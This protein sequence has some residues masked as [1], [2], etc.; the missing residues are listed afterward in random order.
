[1][2][3]QRIVFHVPFKLGYALSGGGIRPGKLIRAF[4]D[5]G[6]AVDVVS[7]FKAQR[8]EAMAAIEDRLAQG[9]PYAFCYAESSVLP[10]MLTEKNQKAFYPFVDFDFFAKLK[11]AG[12]PIGLFYR[13][14]YWKYPYFRERFSWPDRMRRIFFYRLDW[15][16]YK[17][18]LSTLFL[19]SMRLSHL[20]PGRL[21]NMAQECW[22]GHDVAAV[23]ERQAPK[24][25][26]D[27]KLFY[28]GGISSP[29][30]DIT[31]LMRLGERFPVTVSCREEEWQ[32]WSGHY[33]GVRGPV[34]ICHLRDE[35]L[36]RAYA[37][38]NVAAIV[39]NGHEYLSFA[40]PNK[41]FEAVGHG[42]PLLVSEGTRVAEFV[43]EH[44]LGWIV[45]N[46]FADL[47]PARMVAE[48]EAKAAN[49]RAI[50]DENH[51]RARVEIIRAALTNGR[52]A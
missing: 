50:R 35:T 37:E 7:G 44:D 32:E 42:L 12:I 27:L 31:P 30:Y 5:T 45:R 39:R 11:A 34:T 43:A 3:Q 25:P 9:A 33:E 17:R 10:T 36:A 40:M 26:E 51:W 6:Y 24:R 47:D 22:P 38:H 1:M 8:E 29:L 4:E 49:V 52:A 20:L 19:P 14:I 48:W 46:D 41:L 18:L 15:H 13:D 21:R 2:E 28:V 16:F 23:P